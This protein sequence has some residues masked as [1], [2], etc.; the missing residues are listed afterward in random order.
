M[1]F[2]CEMNGDDFFFNQQQKFITN[3]TNDTSNG[4]D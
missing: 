2:N 4:D 3:S 1:E